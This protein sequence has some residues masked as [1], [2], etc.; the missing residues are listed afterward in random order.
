[1]TFVRKLFSTN[2]VLIALSV[3]AAG[4]GVLTSAITENWMWF[5][6]SRSVVVGFGVVLL[7]RAFVAGREPLITI[8]AIEGTKMNTAEV[9]RQP[10]S[11]GTTHNA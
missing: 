1:M 9:Q 11:R 2:W 5:A 8:V 7:S 10:Q 3:A 4:V 6:R